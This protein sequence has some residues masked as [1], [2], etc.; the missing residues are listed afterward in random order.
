[1][2]AWPTASRCFARCGFPSVSRKRL[3]FICYF[4]ARV[5]ALGSVNRTEYRQWIDRV[6]RERKSGGLAKVDN[7][8]FLMSIVPCLFTYVAVS[9][10]CRAHW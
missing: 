7:R 4:S 5:R 10:A 2:S 1:M 8:Q 6:D 9:V 3:R